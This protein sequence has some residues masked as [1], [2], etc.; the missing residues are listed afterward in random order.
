MGVELLAAMLVGM[1]ALIGIAS[2]G[3]GDDSDEDI[4]GES[5]TGDENVDQMIDSGDD[6]EGAGDDEGTDDDEG[7]GDGEGTGD[8]DIADLRDVLEGTDDADVLL[9]DD[10][11]GDIS[12]ADGDDFIVSFGANGV[13]SGGDGDDIIALTS[14]EGTLTGGAGE[15]V[16]VVMGDEDSDTDTHGVI[17]DF[18]PDEDKLLFTFQQSRVASGDV[19]GTT[20]TIILDREEIET[21]NGVATKLTFGPAPG[22]EDSTQG[23]GFSSVVLEGVTLDDFT[24]ANIA[25]G[26]DSTPDDDDAQADF[27]EAV[28]TGMTD[29]DDFEIG[30]EEGETISP[31][32][33][34]DSTVETAAVFGLGGDDE[35]IAEDFFGVDLYGGDGDDRLLGGFSTG[36]LFGGDG[37]D[38]LAT[39]AATTLTGGSGAD[40]FSVFKEGDFGDQTTVITDFVVGEDNLTLGG[41][42]FDLQSEDGSAGTN[43]VT[44]QDT[45]RDGLDGTLVET[46]HTDSE[47]RTGDGPSVFLVGVAA[48]DIPD[49]T[50]RFNPRI[51]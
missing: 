4:A 50:F 45:T 48:A 34:A 27:I 33:G 15:D 12:G 7:T 46:R 9:G 38:L 42:F 40:T 30:T 18:D 6:G 41:I 32:F 11:I 43:S 16:F 23:I 13:L 26:R 49:G 2:G 25:A 8:D 31:S 1:V 21:D 37:D 51:E 19:L 44:L 22:F 35:L 5:L 29:Y 24:D 10:M 17:T 28:T 20:S 36:D 47:G 14:G 39:Q 3:G